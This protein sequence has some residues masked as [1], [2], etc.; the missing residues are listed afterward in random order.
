MK[1]KRNTSFR[2]SVC[3]LGLYIAVAVMSPFLAGS[4]AW[5]CYVNKH[6]LFPKWQD[7]TPSIGSPDHNSIC[8]YPI[9]PY[10]PLVTN[11]STD[12]NLSPFSDQ[13]GK[14]W[15]NRHW[16]GT[17][18]LGRDVL[19][20]MIYGT[21]TALQIGLISIFFAFIIGVTLGILSAYFRDDGI[22][23]NMVQLM[24]VFLAFIMGLFFLYWELAMYTISQWTWI[25]MI[26]C[27]LLL[28]YAIKLL[29]RLKGIKKYPIPFDMMM[30]K[31]IEIRKS[32]PSI[33]ILLTLSSLFSFPSIWNIIL[34]ITILGWIDF[35]R[36]AR[37]ETLSVKEEN[38][39]VSA[40]VL[41]YDAW[42]IMYKQIL[43]NIMPT[44]LVVGCFSIS[45]AILLESTLSFLGMGLPVEQV[46]WGR[47]MS[48]GR[49]MQS[50]WLVVCPGLALFIII[51][52]LNN[53]ASMYQKT[54]TR[55]ML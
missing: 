27:V 8:I 54:G 42:R 44:L 40:K 29:G 9:I 45:S 1:S 36:Y 25:I 12:A 13:P 24:G 3:V 46:T 11:I 7:K 41:G 4:K 52:C 20:G 5:I 33:F 21:V 26:S 39:I 14:S 30:V 50:W 28:I 18:K 55:G 15:R 48:E 47:M 10:D 16:L 51:L 37:A 2:L 6:L 17:D 32:F 35:A 43:P 31:V 34:I 23:L 49:T 53:I 22:S 19:S 38:F